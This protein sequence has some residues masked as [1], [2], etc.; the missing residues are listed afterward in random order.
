MV[1]AATYIRREHRDTNFHMDSPY[2]IITALPNVND[3]GNLR[4]PDRNRAISHKGAAR[5]ESSF[6]HPT[7]LPLQ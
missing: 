6:V 2:H 1:I 4:V 3:N 7:P 5:Y